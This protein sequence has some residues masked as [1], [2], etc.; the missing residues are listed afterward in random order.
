[1]AATPPGA[2]KRKMDYMVDQSTFDEFVKACGRKGFA[3]QI[4]LEQ[5]M[6]KFTQQGQ[7]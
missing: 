6:R 1:M 5:A 3:P 7:L 2:K 4:I